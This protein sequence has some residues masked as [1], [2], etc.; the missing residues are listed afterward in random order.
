MKELF[1][2][3]EIAVVE[4]CFSDSD[5]NDTGGAVA[6]FFFSSRYSS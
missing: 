6:A 2:E 5:V 4:P 1:N 3:F